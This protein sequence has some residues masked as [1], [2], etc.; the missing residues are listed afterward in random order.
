MLLDN[1]ETTINVDSTMEKMKE[2]ILDL[3]SYVRPII[4]NKELLKIMPNE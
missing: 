1:Y 4:S 3:D 2:T